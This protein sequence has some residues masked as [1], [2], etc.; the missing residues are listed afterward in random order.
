MSTTSLTSLLKSLGGRPGGRARG[1]KLP[2]VNGPFMPRNEG[3]VQGQ[4]RVAW[5]PLVHC[6]QSAWKEGGRCSDAQ[7][8]SFNVRPGLQAGDSFEHFVPSSE[9]GVFLHFVCVPLCFVYGSK[10]G[11]APPFEEFLRLIIFSALISFLAC[12]LRGDCD[13]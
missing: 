2:L 4:L 1:I 9:R 11:H 7:V 3:C 6:V 10:G 8:P 12:E 13:L 5:F